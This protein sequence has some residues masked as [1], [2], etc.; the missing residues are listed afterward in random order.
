MAEQQEAKGSIQ[1]IERMMSLLDV[2]ANAPEPATLKMLAQAT[3]LHPSTAHRILA[4]MTQSRL[5]ERHEAS[6]YALGIRLLELGNIV[7]SRINIREVALPF[8]QNLHE[9]IDESINLGIRDQDEIIY[10]ERTSSG[11]SLVRVVYLVGDRAPLHLTSLG[12]LFLAAESV[13]DVCAYAK[14]TGLPGKTPHSLTRLDALEKE[15]D[16]IRRHDVAYDNEE[17]EIGLR[18]LAAPIRDDHG[19]VVAGLSISAPTDRHEPGWAVQI[20]A[21]AEAISNALGY[22]PAHMR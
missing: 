5:V 21:A 15:L 20:K 1:V 10:I 4:V 7:K 12:K 9:T 16:K 2:L 6:T 17:A 22:R 3:G 14:R 13:A 18:C 19:C 11:R 8:M